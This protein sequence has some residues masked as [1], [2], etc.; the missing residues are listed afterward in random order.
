[1][2]VR[3]F[4]TRRYR[5]S[6]RSSERGLPEWTL[7]QACFAS[8]RPWNLRPRLTLLISGNH[9]DMAMPNN[10]S[11]REE[12]RGTRRVMMWGTA[13]ALVVFVALLAFMLWPA[14]TP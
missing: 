8:R 14:V 10:I 7:G 1:M 9:K 2:V 13:I 5:S 6:L 4:L 12:Q 3:H 11:R